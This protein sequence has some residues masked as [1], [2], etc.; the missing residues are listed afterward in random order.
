MKS[1][2]AL[3]L[4]ILF[5]A[6]LFAVDGVITV[7][8]KFKV[9]HTVD[10]LKAVVT[11][12]GMK[13]IAD[14]DHAKAAKSI[15]KRIPPTELVIFGN[16]K[17]GAPMMECARSIAIDLPQKMLIWEDRAGQVWMSYNDPAYIANRH[18]LDKHCRGALKKVART[19]A[20]LSKA[21]GG[22]E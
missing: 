7:K 14:V 16:P 6:P 1:I 5:S 21:A 8:S 12:K 17:I 18:K 10:R 20:N 2:F 11:K 4:C 3:S 9:A 22:M 19:L 15:G 13:V